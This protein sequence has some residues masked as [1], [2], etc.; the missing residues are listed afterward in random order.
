[1]NVVKVDDIIKITGRIDSSNAAL[2]EEELVGACD[3]AEC[4]LD[5]EE[6]EYIS[7]AGLRVLLKLTKSGH[8]LKIIN[9]SSEVYEIFETTGFVEILDVRKALR[10]IDV[11]GLEILG[12]GGTGTVYR[13][14]ADTIVKVFSE[15]MT[16]EDIE[17]ERAHAKAAFVQG[18]PTAIA[19]DLVRVGNGYGNVYEAINSDTLSNYI[20][21]NPDKFDEIIEKYSDLL[22]N[23]SKIHLDTSKFKSYKQIVL[24]RCERIYELFDKEDCD[25]IK[26]IVSCMRDADTLIHGDL[27]PGNIMIQ[28]GEL[29]LIDMAEIS[30][31]P[32]IFDLVAI[33][34]D[35]GV[36]KT[37]Q[38]KTFIEGSI[39]M[40]WEDIESVYAALMKKYYGTEDEEI[41]QKN[42][43][44][45]KLLYAL[46]SAVMIVLAP[47]EIRRKSAPIAKEKL[48]EGVIKPNADTL[49]YIIA[50]M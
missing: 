32:S 4:V 15:Q 37:P 50:N 8:K 19:F 22:K 31:G 3:T 47:D 16:L 10:T 23:L 21:N 33:Y 5:C 26:D 39:G 38:I 40:K 12:R 42:L 18:V 24:N 44:P 14:D 35:M 1:M 36:S 48:I 45:V 20:I 9:V 46:I 7:S 11:T 29:M 25:L 6:L 41:I 28:D 34:R 43:G 30:V 17:A 27:H 13:L 49:K 2:A